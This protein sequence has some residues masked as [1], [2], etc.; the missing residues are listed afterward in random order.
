MTAHRLSENIE[1][2]MQGGGYNTNSL[3]PL[4]DIPQPTL[5]RLVKG[6]TQS[7]KQSHLDKIAKF[8]D[9]S[10]DMLVSGEVSI[11]S[12]FKNGSS[13]INRTEIGTKKI[14]LINYVQAGMWK[15]IIKDFDATEYLLTALDIS[16]KAFALT[17]K[18][19]S[20][21]PDF[22]E[23]D[24]IVIDTEVH[25]LPGDFVVAMNGSNEATFKK[26]RPRGI[27]EKGQ[28]VFELV[29]LND[30]YPTIRSDIEPIKIIGTMME[31][32]RYRKR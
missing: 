16:D 28:D 12:V 20:M 29:P 31:H 22:K 6:T 3:A 15:E 27:N 1:K 26:Y 25:P 18:G 7:P 30:D 19:E 4:V 32:R 10:I 21:L 17:I 23:G 2:L 9:V 13:N 14:P 8:F 11:N 24:C 5:H